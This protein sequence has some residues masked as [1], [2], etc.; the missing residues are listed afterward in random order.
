MTD[1]RTKTEQLMDLAKG[2]VFFPFTEPTVYSPISG[3]KLSG[4]SRMIDIKKKIW[5]DKNYRKK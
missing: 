2:S 3:K 5:G 1:K 4:D